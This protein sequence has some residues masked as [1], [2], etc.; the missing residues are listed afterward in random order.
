MWKEQKFVRLIAITLIHVYLNIAY[1]S[2][3]SILYLHLF[4]S[5]PTLDEC[6]QNMI[7]CY[8]APT[9]NPANRCCKTCTAVKIAYKNMGW[10]LDPPN[11]GQCLS[12]FISFEWVGYSLLCFNHVVSV[13][14]YFMF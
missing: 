10:N 5:Y 6:E 14:Q 1:Y 2:F 12:K 8:G 9:K 11:I 4:F 7:S 3:N 13:R